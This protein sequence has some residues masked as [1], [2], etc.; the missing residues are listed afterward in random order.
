MIRLKLARIGEY[1]DATFGV[2]TI[3]S[4]PICVTLEDKWRNNEKMISCIPSGH[5]KLKKH[6]SPKFG[7]C[8]K[9]QD[10]PSRSDILIHAGNTDVDTHGCI[11]LGMTFG[12]MGERAAILSSRTAMGLFMTAMND[13]DE[14]LL[15][16]R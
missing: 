1:Q 4:R 7:L 3:D 10:V 11:L 2:L 13:V 5:Y 12:M 8:Y 15:E 6:D 16:V 9:V 14:A